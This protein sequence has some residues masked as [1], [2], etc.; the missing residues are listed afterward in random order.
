VKVALGVGYF[1]SDDGGG[2]HIVDLSDPTA[3]SL[4]AQITSGESGFNNVHNVF[5]AEGYL[6][7]SDLAS[8]TVKV[9]DVGDPMNPFF[10]RDIVTPDTI[11][12]HDTTVVGGRLYASGFDGFTYIYD[13]SQVGTMAPSLL[14]SVPS[15][16]NSHSNWVNSDGTLLISAQEISD[17]EVTIYDISVPGSPI[18]LSTLDRTSLGIDAFSPHNPVLLGDHLLFVSWYQAGVQ[19]IDISDPANPVHLGGYDTFPS[20][21]SGFDGNWGVYPLL[22]LNRVLA[23]DLDGGLFI[24]DARDLVPA[25][26][27]TL[28]PAAR[29]LLALTM[30]AAAGAVSR[31]RI[32]GPAFSGSS[33]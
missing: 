15:G 27:P 11:F 30:L 6:Y 33:R 16:A 7:E 18:L 1:A 10:V 23:S 8:A 22:G 12:I 21:V 31:R 4:I 20:S 28:G 14:G 13:V 29:W 25:A 32:A 17:G 2:V 19:L 26:V 5:V 3:P 24:L 9:F